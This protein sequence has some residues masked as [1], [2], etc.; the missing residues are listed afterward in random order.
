MGPGVSWYS[1]VWITPT[2]E[3][4]PGVGLTP[5]MLDFSAGAVMLELV[6]ECQFILKQELCMYERADLSSDGGCSKAKSNGNSVSARR[7]RGILSLAV[8]SG[9]FPA[10][11]RPAA[12]ASEVRELREV[13][14]S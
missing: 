6:F 7:A 3:V 11:G 9:T 8:Y 10:N 4:N 2:R 13:C 14:L 5:T 12:G 1:F